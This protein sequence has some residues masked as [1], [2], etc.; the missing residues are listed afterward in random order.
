MSGSSLVTRAEI[1]RLAR[2]VEVEP[3]VFEGLAAAPLADLRRL[4]EQVT[5][6]MFDT[7]RATF[8]RIAAVSRLLP[9]S[10]AAT[11]ARRAFGPLLTARLAAHVDPQRAA[12]LAAHLPAEFLA[13]VAVALDPRRADALLHRLPTRLVEPVARILLERD[14]HAAAARYIE[15]LPLTVLQDLLPVAD[16]GDILHLGFLAEAPEVIDAIAGGLPE[17]RLAELVVAAHELGLWDEV[18]VFLGHVGPEQRARLGDIAAAQDDELL[19]GLVRAAQDAGAWE[20]LLPIVGMMSSANRRRLAS[21]PAV[22]EAEVLHS[23]VA[24]AARSDEWPD[25]LPLVPELPADARTQ[26]VS[27][28]ADLPRALRER[29]V[30]ALVDPVRRLPTEMRARLAEAVVDERVAKLLGDL[31]AAIDPAR[32]RREPPSAR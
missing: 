4:R 23:I 28:V 24:T 25:L 29:T 13:D 32:E 7:H 12:E 22:H 3:E 26:V 10:L 16:D 31:A 8:M 5:S 19:T 20:L 18:L 17:E 2:L 30:R 11:I 27:A 15:V 1:Q 21:L 14:E 9:P 6:V